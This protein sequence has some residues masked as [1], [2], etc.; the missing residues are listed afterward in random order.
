MTHLVLGKQVKGRIVNHNTLQNNMKTT[1]IID[2]YI[3][4]ALIE[5]KRTLTLHHEDAPKGIRIKLDMFLEK[6]RRDIGRP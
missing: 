4:E 2:D 5:N 6:E 3:I 1:P